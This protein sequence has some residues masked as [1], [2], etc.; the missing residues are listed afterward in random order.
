MPGGQQRLQTLLKLGQFGLRQPPFVGEDLPH[1]GGEAEIRVLR[2]C[3]QP[4]PGVV[5]G[6]GPVKGDVDLHRGKQGGQESKTVGALEPRGID[7]P[8]PVGIIPARRADA[9]LG[10]WGVHLGGGGHGGNPPPGPQSGQG[11]FSPL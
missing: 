2:H 1:L 5:G 8:L 4:A 10:V 11:Q 9:E 6:D 7:H 3:R